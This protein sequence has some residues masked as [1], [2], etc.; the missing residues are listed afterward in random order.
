MLR[1]EELSRIRVPS[2]I[3]GQAYWAHG[4]YSERMSSD[5]E[6]YIGRPHAAIC[7]QT[8]AVRVDIGLADHIS[9]ADAG[10]GLS[11]LHDSGFISDETYATRA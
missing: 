5:D 10:D 6:S 1:W 7:A 4:Q 11:I 2:L 8:R 3:M 9:F